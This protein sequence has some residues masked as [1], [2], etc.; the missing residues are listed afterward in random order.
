M[1]YVMVD[2]YFT[3]FWI[4]M[5]EKVKYSNNPEADN[6]QN[7]KTY[8]LY[9]TIEKDIDNVLNDISERNPIKLREYTPTILVYN[10]VKDLPM[11]ENPAHV[12]KNIL[13]EQQAIKLG[14]KLNHRDNYHGLGKEL[15][16]KVIDILNNPRAVFKNINNCNYLILTVIKDKFNNNVVVPVE[17]ETTTNINNMK[18]DINRIKSVYGFD[19]SRGYNLNDYIKKNLNENKFKKI[20]GQKKEQGTGFSTTASSLNDINISQFDAKVKYDISN[21]SNM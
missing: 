19:N 14:L 12:R 18:I 6:N 5:E 15:Y 3:N 17:I 20:Y 1:D 10:G 2:N 4:V 8:K 9:N 13:N 16:I 11:Y 7:I 21:N